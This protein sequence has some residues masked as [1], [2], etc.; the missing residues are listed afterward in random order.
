M[1]RWHCFIDGFTTRAQHLI[2]IFNQGGE[3]Y[4]ALLCRLPQ[5]VLMLTGY[6]PI[7]GNTFCLVSLGEN[8]ELEIRLAVPKE[9][10]DFVP[11]GI[12]VEE[13]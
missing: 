6:L 9:E 11:A 12:A 4:A 13:C 3:G 5:H 10:E 2:E 8:R 1:S 7:L